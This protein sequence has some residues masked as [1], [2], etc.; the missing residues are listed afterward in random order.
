M[1]MCVCVYT[2]FGY[3]FICREPRV[4]AWGGVLSRRPSHPIA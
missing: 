2:W 1:C 4:C 3:I